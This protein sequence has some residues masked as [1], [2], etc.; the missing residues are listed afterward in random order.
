MKLKFYCSGCG[1]ETY[2]Y[3]SQLTRTDQ[4]YCTISCRNKNYKR[5]N[6]NWKHSNYIDSIERT[7]I[8][9]NKKFYTKNAIIEQKRICCGSK[10]AGIYRGKNRLGSHH[11]E[12]TKVKISEKNKLFNK[13]YGNSFLMGKS[14]GRHTKESIA[15][16]SKSNSGKE[17]HWKGRIFQ[18]SGPK[19]SFKLRSSYELFYANWMDSNGIE[20]KYEPQFKLS[21][22]M[23]FSPDFQV[24]GHD[25][26][27]IVEIKGFWTEKAKNKWNLFTED[28]PNLDKQVLYKNDLIKLGM[29][30]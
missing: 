29:E 21:N 3:L 7:C 20:W 19:G 17:P 12:D 25:R 26:I 18:Y 30:V 5:V 24:Y 22:G 4:V 27:I 13:E 8:V 16:L 6:P 11:T 15:K 9:C 23:T 2:K 10:C 14:K 1:V 28:F